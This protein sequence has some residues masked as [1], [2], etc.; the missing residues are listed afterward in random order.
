MRSAWQVDLRSCMFATSSVSTSGRWACGSFSRSTRRRRRGRS[1]ASTGSCSK[2]TC[3]SATRP[4][5]PERTLRRRGRANGLWAL[6]GFDYPMQP[7]AMLRWED[8]GRGTRGASKPVVYGA[9][10]CRRLSFDGTWEGRRLTN[11]GAE[12]RTGLVKCDRPG[13]QGG[14]GK[15]GS[16]RNC[17]PSSQPKGRGW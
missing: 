15:R 8:T 17:E 3:R 14:L 2:G 13:S 12:V 7:D 16:W 1:P 9:D 6:G 11:G 10:A 5:V 4:G